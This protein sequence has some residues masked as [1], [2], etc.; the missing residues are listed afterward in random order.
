[1]RFNIVELDVQIKMGP[2][3]AKGLVRPIPLKGLPE[4]WHRIRDAFRVLTGR[5]DALDWG[6]I[7]GD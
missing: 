2:R 5:Y 4:L 3:D 6:P 1:M 7:D